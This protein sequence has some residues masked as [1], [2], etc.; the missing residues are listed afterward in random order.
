MMVGGADYGIS[1]LTLKFEQS[2]GIQLNSFRKGMIV[3][4]IGVNNRV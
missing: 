3:P 4:L 2:F 1:G